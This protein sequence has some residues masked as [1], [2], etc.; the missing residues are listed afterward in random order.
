M[1]FIRGEV[2][3]EGGDKVLFPIEYVSA[4]APIMNHLGLTWHLLA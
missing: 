2:E 1:K 3:I 4:K